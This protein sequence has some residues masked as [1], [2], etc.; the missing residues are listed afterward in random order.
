MDIYGWIKALLYLPRLC[1]RRVA[2]SPAALRRR[3]SARAGGNRRTA[4]TPARTRRGLTCES[5]LL[6]VRKLQHCRA[7]CNRRLR[8]YL[9]LH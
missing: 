1:K 5:S 4:L 2:R 8:R 7:D 3:S 9:D 6:G